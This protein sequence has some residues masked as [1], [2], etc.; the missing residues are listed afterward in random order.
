MNQFVT[1][2]LALIVSSAV[3]LYVCFSSV[4]QTYTLRIIHRKL[5]GK[6]L[7]AFSDF[8]IHINFSLNNC[9][10]YISIKLF[11][12]CRCLFMFC[13]GAEFITVISLLP[14]VFI[15]NF[16][17]TEIKWLIQGYNLARYRLL[18]RST[19]KKSHAQFL[20]LERFSRFIRSKFCLMCSI[21][22]LS[23]PIGI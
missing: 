18:W 13:L 7:V 8:D 9:H 14:I 2:L 11:Q 3:G 12:S 6:C 5:C 1:C 21:S 22:H 16:C 4:Y 20:L 15:K 19:L 17:K 10:S 23:F